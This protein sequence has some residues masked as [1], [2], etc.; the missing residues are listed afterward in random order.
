[1]MGMP[2]IGIPCGSEVHSCTCGNVV[3]TYVHIPLETSRH[4][5]LEKLFANLQYPDEVVAANGWEGRGEVYAKT[6]YVEDPDN[7]NQPTRT[8]ILVVRFTANTPNIVRVL[9]DG[10]E[11]LV[12]SHLL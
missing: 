10:K 9:Y 2:S 6:L 8:R 1:M 5:K 4:A 12:P 7:P 11:M 3:L